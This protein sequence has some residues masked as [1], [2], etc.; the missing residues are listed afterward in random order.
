MTPSLRA[1]I[2]HLA[3]ITWANKCRIK[4]PA[5]A[6]SVD[7]T[8][9]MERGQPTDWVDDALMGRPAMLTFDEGAEVCRVSRRTF[10]RWVDAGRIESKQINTRLRL[11][12]RQ[13]LAKFLRG[14][15]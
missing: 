14:L 3:K 11:V 5:T 7:D 15:P 8:E 10:R 6:P 2:R 4:N 1:S 12:P 13:N 9:R